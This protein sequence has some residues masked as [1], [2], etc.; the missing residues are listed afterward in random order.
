MTDPKIVKVISA[1]GKTRI[2][3]MEDGSIVER[4][5][6]HANWRNNNPGNL[7]FELPDNASEDTRLKR[8]AEAQQRYDGIVGLDGNG[9]AIFETAE[10][11]RLAQIKLADRKASEKPE[12][13]LEDYV[14][15]YAKDDYAGKA[16]HAAYLKKI[17]DIGKENGIDLSKE[18]S[19]ASLNPREKGVLVDAMKQVEGSRIGETRTVYTPGSGYQLKVGD[20]GD[21]VNGLRA[22]LAKAGYQTIIDPQGYYGS[23]TYQAVRKFQKDNGLPETGT[24]DMRTLNVLG[25]RIGAKDADTPVFMRSGNTPPEKPATDAVATLDKSTLDKSTPDKSTLDKNAF[26]RSALDNSRTAPRTDAGGLLLSDET[27]PQH[28]LY[29]QALTQVTALQSQTEPPVVPP[30]A[31]DPKNI[32]AAIAAAAI[33]AGMTQIDSLTR[34]D[35]GKRLFA[36][37]G[38]D[39]SAAHAMYARVDID[40]AARQPIALSSQ[41]AETPVQAVPQQMPANASREQDTPAPS[42]RPLTV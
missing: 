1:E 9:M 26:D 14:K 18:R 4:T 35:D 34:S 30:V 12:W 22:S 6:G 33:A 27:H 20:W 32:A 41:Q 15:F 16:N 42:M 37:Q 5:G 10:A 28:T 13:S 7:K 25:N 24:A 40:Q 23:G 19:I 36:V 21:D 17:E 29:R 2:Y 3:E 38:E 11:G 31:G 39:P 8:L